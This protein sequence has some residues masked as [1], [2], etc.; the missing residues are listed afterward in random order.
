MEPNF[1]GNEMTV[2]IKTKKLKDD[3]QLPTKGTEGAACFDLYASETVI[4]ESRGGRRKIPTGI[5]ME[6]P[7]GYC[8]RIYSRSSSFLKG[9]DVGSLVC[10]SDYRGEIFVMCGYDAGNA[11]VERGRAETYVVHKGDRIAQIKIEQLINTTFVEADT[12]KETARGTGGY[13]STGQ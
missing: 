1:Q 12:L 10:D 9:L 4:L 2:F 11:E 7:D 3:A 6:I 8:G 13:G 5:A